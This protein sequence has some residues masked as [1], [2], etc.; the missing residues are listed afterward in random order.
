MATARLQWAREL[1]PEAKR[2]A[3]IRARHDFNNAHPNANAPRSKAEDFIV[4]ETKG[5]SEKYCSTKQYTHDA[6]G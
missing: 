2:A 3:S 6:L 4:K 1:V 5:N